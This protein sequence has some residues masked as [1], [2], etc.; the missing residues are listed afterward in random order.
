MIRLAPAARTVGPEPYSD[1]VNSAVLLDGAVVTRCRRRVHLEHDPAVHGE[2]RAGLD[3][4]V[5]RRIADARAHRRAVADRLAEYHLADWAEVPAE[6]DIEQRGSLTLELLRQGTPLVWGGVL[7]ADTPA[8]RRGGVELLVRHRGGY[9]PVLVVRHKVTDPGCGARTS[10]LAQPRLAR[11]HTDPDRKVRPQSRDQLRLAHAVR[12]LQAA[13]LAARGRATG[14]VIGLDA[15]V[16]VWHNL[17]A[18]NWP[19]GHTAMSE[20]DTRFAD[21]LA[22]A[23]A[24]ATEAQPLAQPSRVTECRSCPWWL[25]CGPALR[26]SRDVSMVLR[27]EDAVALRA[28]GVSTVD[29]LAALDPAGEPPA[30]MAGTSVRDAVWLARAW[31]RDLTLVRRNQR[32]VMPRADVEV[33]VDMESF[34]EAG[35]YLWGCLLS[36]AE[37]GLPHGYQAFATWEPVPTPDEARSF[38][39]FWRWLS[40]VRC[41]AAERGHNFA[42]YCY[43]EQAENRWMLS[44]AA[45]F[46]G[47]P[48]I[49][50]TV[51]VQE[52]IASDQWVDL[53]QVVGAEFLCPLGKG[54]KTIA[55][56][57]GFAWHDPE[58]S[59]ENSMRWYSDA[60]GLNGGEPD[61]TQ[62]A[63]LL[64]Y[65]ADDVRATRALREWMSSE[66]VN[67]VPYAGDL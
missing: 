27:G 42:A 24:A 9:L 54:L 48:G 37:V 3:V 35:A 57:A 47:A 52:F 11:A 16:V 60:V 58:A 33:D 4:A 2:S 66:Q 1:I 61:L 14:G 65:N 45:R 41:R 53:Y 19:G 59:G 62:R 55:P 30:P 6:L 34:D 39:E 21:R 17:E 32:I 29:A 63:R 43:N 51:E 10:P 15:D 20:Y 7:P 25:T 64:T 22:I 50:A 46:A 44:S 56:A 5:Q 67:D 38:A 12:L 23:Q 28:V 26:A 18:P 36:G 8:G 13:G 49:P 31:Q 40:D